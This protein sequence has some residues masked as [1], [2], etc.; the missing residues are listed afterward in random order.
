MHLRLPV[1][2]AIPRLPLTIVSIRVDPY[3]HRPGLPLAPC[4][5]NSISHSSVLISADILRT[6]NRMVGSEKERGRE[7]GFIHRLPRS[8][9]RLASFPKT[10][11][12]VCLRGMTTRL[13]SSILL[14]FVSSYPFFRSA[15]TRSGDPR[16]KM[17]VFSHAGRGRA[18]DM[19]YNGLC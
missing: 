5:L 4:N 2:P 14:V 19:S 3:A 6:R 15:T 16:S 9:P 11:R 7:G 10:T 18:I 1:H 8:T 13:S 12:S 17:G